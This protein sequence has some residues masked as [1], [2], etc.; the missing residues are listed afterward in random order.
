MAADA[1]LSRELKEL[2]AELSSPRRKRSPP[3]EDHASPAADNTPRAP[4][5]EE[6]AQEEQLKGEL[7]EL[8]DTVTEFVEDTEKNMSAHPTASVVGALLVGIVI[9]R[10]LGRR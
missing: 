8:V 9:G 5:P 3:A 10:L 6:A 4:S 2:H 7:R 1:V